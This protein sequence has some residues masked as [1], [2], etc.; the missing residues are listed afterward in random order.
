MT[1]T[2]NGAFNSKWH[3]NLRDSIAIRER[4]K[5]TRARFV[6]SID[7]S[8]SVGA[9]TGNYTL[10]HRHTALA[11]RQKRPTGVQRTFGDRREYENENAA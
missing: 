9:A 5:E 3:S 2:R 6:A 7:C 11:T 4:G 10:R 1:A 8:R